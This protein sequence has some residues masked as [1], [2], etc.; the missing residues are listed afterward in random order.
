MMSSGWNAWRNNIT[1]SNLT[2]YS[3]ATAEAFFV[4]TLGLVPP[5][6]PSALCRCGI[7]AGVESLQVLTLPRNA[8][9]AYVTLCVCVC[10]YPSSCLIPEPPSSS[11][12]S[13]VMAFG[14]TSPVPASILGLP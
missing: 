1:S 14:G 3:D 8:R 9:R 7:T 5:V 13:K 4:G 12:S 2:A 10:A 11:F 6:D